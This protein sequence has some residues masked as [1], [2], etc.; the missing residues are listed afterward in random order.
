MKR[1]VLFS[2]LA[3]L[4]VG[5]G[6]EKAPAAKKGSGMAPEEIAVAGKGMVES[7]GCLNCHR[8]AGQGRGRKEL[9]HAGKNDAAW[10]LA[11]LKDPMS[12]SPGSKMPSFSTL[13]EEKL[14][15]LSEYLASLK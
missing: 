10:H 1:Y 9:D 3:A 6:G 12:K 13:G 8:L 11:H 2:C 15:I 14:G 5:C 4:L 7:L